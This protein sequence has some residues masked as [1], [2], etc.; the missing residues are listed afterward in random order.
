[1]FGKMFSGVAGMMVQ[2]YL[3]RQV[4]G[5]VAGTVAKRGGGIPGLLIWIVVS[6]LIN[7]F[8]SRPR[9][10]ETARLATTGR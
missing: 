5:R 9:S 4:A 10:A 6:Y 7:R 2:R 8:I 1:M 3:T